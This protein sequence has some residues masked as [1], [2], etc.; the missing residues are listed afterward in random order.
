MSLVIFDGVAVANTSG[1]QPP[2]QGLVLFDAIAVPNT[3]GGFPSVTLV[4]DSRYYI[5]G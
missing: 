5:R 1:G 4:I 3:S 2:G